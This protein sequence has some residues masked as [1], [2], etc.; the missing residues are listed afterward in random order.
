MARPKYQGRIDDVVER[1]VDVGIDAVFDRV[2]DFVQRTMEGQRAATAAIPPEARRSTYKC[3]GCHK[4]FPFEALAMVSAR[5]DGYAACV[6]CFDFMWHAA[7]EKMKALK[8][9]AGDFARGA[10]RGATRPGPAPRRPVEPRRTPPWE[11]LGIDSDASVEEIKKAY[12]KL[13]AVAH[14]DRVPPGASV[15]EI[16][17]A[18]ARFE[19]LTRCYNAMLKVRSPA[20]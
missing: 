16:E 13:A 5:G 1:A 2:T 8:Q 9:G 12:R 4:V 10:A 7:D 18:R 17:T 3:A 20:T 15:E 19:E 11:V 6:S 14:P